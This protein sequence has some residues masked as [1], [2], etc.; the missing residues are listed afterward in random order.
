MTR[1]ITLLAA[2]FLFAFAA[3]A[4]SLAQDTEAQIL[5]SGGWDNQEYDIAGDWR[6][7]TR[8]DGNYL[9]LSDE[10]RT[11]RGPDLKIFFHTA[12]AGEVTG[13]NAAEG[14][15]LTEL[16]RNRGGQ[17]YLLPADFDLADYASVVIHCERFSKLW[18]AGD[19]NA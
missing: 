16:D 12:E 3:P 9:V 8:A 2:A 1:L 11:R 5:A 15:L 14:F 17:E 18:G 6:I 10:F 7:E 19:L 4:S 13:N